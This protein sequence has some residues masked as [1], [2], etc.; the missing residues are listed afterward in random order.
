MDRPDFWRALDRLV[1][2]SELRV[3]RPKGSRHPRYAE[4]VYP[5]DYGYLEGTVS[6]DGQGVDVWVGSLPGRSV[7]GIICAVDL[8]KR[9]A[10]VKILLGCTPEEARQVLSLHNS[11]DQSAMLLERP[12]T[13]EM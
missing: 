3:D 1:Q 8:L 9:D 2:G 11:G 5:L 10:E 13:G 12:K 4:Q 7:T 6:G